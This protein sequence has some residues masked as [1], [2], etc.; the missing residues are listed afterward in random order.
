MHFSSPPHLLLFTINA[1]DSKIFMRMAD[2]WLS[3]GIRYKSFNA[4]QSEVVFKVS[5]WLEKQAI[6]NGSFL[7]LNLGY[8]CTFVLRNCTFVFAICK[9]QLHSGFHWPNG[10][11]RSEFCLRCHWATSCILTLF[12]LKRSFPYF[13]LATGI[14]SN[15]F[16]YSRYLDA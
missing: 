15:T 14:L 10:Q 16:L 1:W 13:F 9:P 3:I 2:K 7:K 6:W 8:N 11:Y 12:P 4:A 5:L